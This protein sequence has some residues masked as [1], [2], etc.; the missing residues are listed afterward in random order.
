MAYINGID[1][2]VKHPDYN[3]LKR[4]WDI[5]SSAFLGQV[6][7]YVPHLSGQTPDE[8]E[9]YI[10]RSAYFNM[11]EKTVTA[12]CGAFT[13]K[14]YQME[15]YVDFPGTDDGDGTTFIQE[16]YRDILLGAR[17]GLLVDVDEDGASKIIN[18]NAANIVNWYGD[19]HEIGDFVVIEE[20]CLVRD[21]SNPYLLKCEITHRE[22]YIDDEGYY[23]VRIWTQTG[24]NNYLHSEQ[25]PF[26]INGQRIQF[27][28]LWVVTPY[29]NSW[30]IYNAP[31]FS[32]AS[33]NLQHFRQSC[34]LAHY[35]HFMAL[36][37]FTITGDLYTYTDNLGNQ[38]QSLI[39][40]GSTKEALHLTQG[41]SAMYVE[42]SGT[43]FGM[44]Q[45]EMKATEERMYITGT[46]LLSSKS[47]VESA[48]ALQLRSGSETAALDTIAHSLESALNGA[49]Q[50]CGYIDNVPN[51]AIQLN[52]DFTSAVQDP[53]AISSLLSLYTANVISLDQFLTELY[54][55][56]VVQPNPEPVTPVLT[57]DGVSTPN[58]DDSTASS[59]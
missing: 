2:S 57:E 14:P 49:L 31:L 15:G 51:A 13:R 41:S 20:S 33:L 11:V 50:L 8:Y 55:G 35:A 4:K 17:I 46:R 38:T 59:E 6:V 26:L 1:P 43:S 37:T 29:D 19:G 48:Q 22:L 23:A 47:G 58:T 3:I 9:A 32:Q 10:A 45:G 27:I 54:L 24:K 56:E 44:L 16:C 34:D 30:C 7:D 53:S 28:P 40:M 21:P 25:P 5:C 39:K 52:T 36:P 12:V 18:F 42:V